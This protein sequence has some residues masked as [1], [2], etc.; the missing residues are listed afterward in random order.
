MPIVEIKMIE[1]RTVDTK[2]EVVRAVTEA[3]VQ[4]ASVKPEDV[5]IHIVDLPKNSFGRAGKLIIDR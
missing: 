5:R 3:L 2:R 4:T 1:G